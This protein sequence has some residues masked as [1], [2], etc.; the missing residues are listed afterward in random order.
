MPKCHICGI[1]SN[2]SQM[3]DY[4]VYS[5]HPR[6]EEKNKEGNDIAKSK[7]NYEYQK[8]LNTCPIC[9]TSNK[10]FSELEL[11]NHLMNEHTKENLMDRI[12][13]DNS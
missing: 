4:N 2:Y 5:V 11:K 7:L 13:L 12:L 6:C 8:V 3:I 1:A 9:K 10:D